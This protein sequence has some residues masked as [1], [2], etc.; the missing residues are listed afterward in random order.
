ME[1]LNL[2]LTSDQKGVGDMLG[3]YSNNEDAK[4]KLFEA[5]LLGDPYDIN[6]DLT[7]IG[8]NETQ[9]LVDSLFFNLQLKIE[10]VDEETM[11][12]LKN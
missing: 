12:D 9:K 5:L 1:M 8:K 10:D 3:S 2:L 4:N 6:V 11:N 7:D